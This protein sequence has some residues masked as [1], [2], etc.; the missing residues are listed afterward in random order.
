MRELAD[1]EA[2]CHQI[3]RLI[4]SIPGRATERRESSGPHATDLEGGLK[5]ASSRRRAG[6]A[7]CQ[8]QASGG[9]VGRLRASRPRGYRFPPEIISHAVWLYH[10]FALSFRDVDDLLAPRG[11]EVTYEAIRKWCRRFGPEFAG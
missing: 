7:H 5:S 11:V 8:V 4:F 6:V 9:R 10:R 3:L 2:Q 1:T